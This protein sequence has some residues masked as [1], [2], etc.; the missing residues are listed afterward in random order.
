VFKLVNVNLNGSG[1][2]VFGTRTASRATTMSGRTGATVPGEAAPVVTVTSVGPGA[3]DAVV[4]HVYDVV[5]VGAGAAGFAAALAAKRADPR[6][7]VLLLEGLD[8]VG[9][10]TA[11]SGGV[12]WIPNNALQRRDPRFRDVPEDRSKTL[13]LMARISFPTRYAPA[14][15]TGRFG[16]SQ[17]EYDGLANFYDHGSELTEYL[18]TENVLPHMT[19]LSVREYYAH[20]PENTRPLGRALLPGRPDAVRWM[21]QALF[22]LIA[23]LLRGAIEGWLGR[24]VPAFKA[25]NFAWSPPANFAA[26]GLGADLIDQLHAA[27]KRAGVV[28]RTGQRVESVL[29]Q[30]LAPGAA[31]AG[32]GGGG[33]TVRV[34]GVRTTTATNGAAQTRTTTQWGARRGVILASGGFAQNQAMLDTHS[35]VADATC[36][37]PGATGTSVQVAQ[38][39]GGRLEL[40]SEAW[41]AQSVLE[42]AW[43]SE[44]GKRGRRPAEMAGA[45]TIFFMRGGSMLLVD[46]TGRRAVNE[47]APYDER[48][49]IHATGPTRRLLFLIADRRAVDEVGSTLLATLPQNPRDP[50]YV[51]AATV[52]ALAA[53]LRARVEELRTR[54]EAR[55]RMPSSF[56]LA[57]DF[58]AG[59]AATLARFN[60]F[61]RAGRDADFHRGESPAEA[62]W[63]GVKVDVERGVNPTLRALQ[64]PYYAV[65]VC[66]T[67]L[68]TKG[69]PA[70]DGYSRVLHD[71]SNMPIPGLYAAGNA[72]ASRSGK[73]Y[74]QAGTTIGLAMVTGWVAGGHAGAQADTTRERATLSS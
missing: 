21:M 70:T 17:V 49:R 31:M 43:S 67:I 71:A 7:H 32:G 56:V 45:E 2:V 5:I 34:V 15:P 12:A 22:A 69:G 44:S 54:P 16:L 36:A 41:W 28:I 51:T 1:A 35:I 18:L 13:Q 66:P 42:H 37:C 53:G 6:A 48:A 39:L 30:G 72:A 65:L 40:M 55:G 61:A 33:P 64:P 47:K 50:A 25:L 23:L 3:L 63:D 29:V 58:E 68:D 11:K 52:P 20:Y 24:W 46:S 60:E 10:T 57:D 26:A 73:G 8:K 62:D 4:D 74:Y 19:M 9:G 27:A 14:D 59:L 38:A